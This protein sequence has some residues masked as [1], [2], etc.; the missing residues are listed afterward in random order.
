MK[1]SYKDVSHPWG[2][3]SWEDSATIAE[4]QKLA[5]ALL[6][7]ILPPLPTSASSASPLTRSPLPPLAERSTVA[8]AGTKSSC[9]AR[10]C[11]LAQLARGKERQLSLAK[12]RSYHR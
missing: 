9:R 8:P 3:G 11:L 4:E 10:R 1:L 7:P 2:R 6:P 12:P 5:L